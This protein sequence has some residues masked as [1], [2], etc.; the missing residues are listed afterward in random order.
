MSINGKALAM[1]RKDNIKTPI[2]PGEILQEDFLE[3][4]GITAYRLA[5]D[6]GIQQTHVGLILKGRRSITAATALRLGKYFNMDP[7]FWMNLQ[8]R[9]DLDVAH[10]ELDGVIDKEVVAR[11][12]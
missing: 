12:A 11:V 8:K 10:D 6:I 1:P 3:P 4:M 9:Y 7:E 5:K 2:H